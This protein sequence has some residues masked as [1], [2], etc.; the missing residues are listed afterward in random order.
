MSRVRIADRLLQAEL[1]AGERIIVDLIALGAGLG[2]AG[3]VPPRPGSID[4]FIDISA[5]TLPCCVRR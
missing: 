5:G 1:E 2:S 4:T 3:V